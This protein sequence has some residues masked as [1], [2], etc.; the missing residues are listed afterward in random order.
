[1]GGEGFEPSKSLTTDLQSAPF[2]HSGILPDEKEFNMIKKI[3]KEFFSF[4]HFRVFVCNGLLGMFILNKS[5][6]IEI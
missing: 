2:G 6:K 3:V 4:S 1:M 5:Y